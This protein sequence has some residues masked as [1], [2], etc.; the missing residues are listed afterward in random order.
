M[1]V[2]DQLEA[3]TIGVEL[4]QHGVHADVVKSAQVRSDATLVQPVE[5]IAV[6][7]SPRES[8]SA[9]LVAE[10]CSQRPSSGR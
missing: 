9:E 4:R 2:D 7:G 1:I 8:G 5:A 10:V 3:E 6:S